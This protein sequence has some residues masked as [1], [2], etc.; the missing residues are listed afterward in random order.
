MCCCCSS[1]SSSFSS[2]PCCP[3]WSVLCDAAR[4][5]RRQKNK[6]IK[7]L[8]QQSLKTIATSC[9]SRTKKSMVSAQILHPIFIVA[10]GNHTPPSHRHVC[11]WPLAVNF[12]FFYFLLFLTLGL[13]FSQH[14][15][16]KHIEQYFLCPMETY[17]HLDETVLRHDPFQNRQALRLLVVV[18]CHLMKDRQH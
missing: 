11:H 12:L 15:S 13:A 9:S 6:K 8:K 1:S 18:V 14:L 7:K 17:A 2:L 5:V 10:S 3:V 4:G 16:T